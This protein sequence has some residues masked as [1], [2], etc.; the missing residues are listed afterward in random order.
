MLCSPSSRPFVL[1]RDQTR[2]SSPAQLPAC[3]HSTAAGQKSLGP[4]HRGSVFNITMTA[5]RTVNITENRGERGGL[6]GDKSGKETDTSICQAR[7]LQELTPFPVGA[8]PAETGVTLTKGLPT[9]GAGSGRGPL[10]R[11]WTCDPRCRVLGGH[12]VDV[13]TCDCRCRVWGGSPCGCVTAGAGSGLCG[14]PLP[15]GSDPV[16]ADSTGALHLRASHRL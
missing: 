10:L 16:P 1:S 12:P 2:P 9:K 11:L 6:L 3:F 15:H 5:V 14:S 4:Q 13:W 8:Q 7:R